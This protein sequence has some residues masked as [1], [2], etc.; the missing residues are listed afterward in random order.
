MSLKRLLGTLLVVCLITWPLLLPSLA[1][2]EPAAQGSCAGNVLLNPGFEDGFSDRG[3]GQVTVAN[4][5]N[6]WYQDGPGQ[7]EGY[8]RRPEYKP[9]DAK[10]HT[11]RRIH[12][13]NFAQKLFTTF[14]THNAGLFQQVQVSVGSQLTFSA[15]VQA[16]SSQDPNP[17]KVVAPGNYHITVGIDP[18]GGTDGTSSNVVWVE[19][20]MEYNTWLHPE[21]QATAKA[22]T[23]TVFI[24]GYN[25]FRDN[26]NDSYWD[27]AC[28]TVVKPTPRTTNT[29]K[30]TPTRTLTPTPEA[31]PTPTLTRTPMPG[32]ICISVFEDAN[33]NGRRDEGEKLVAGAVVAI[34]DS[35]RMELE[36]HTTDGLSEPTC[37]SDLAAGTYYLKRLNPV[38]YVSTV[39][40]DW[41]VAVVTGANTSVELGCKF[42]PVP[43]ATPTASPPPLPTATPTPR[44]V[45]REL[46]HSV[47]QVSGILLAAFALFILLGLRYLRKLT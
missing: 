38:G 24:R 20:R 3:A 17:D 28:L 33:E 31:S 6:P 12:S 47:Y 40:D 44:P 45:L 10:L 21:V 35:N 32:G 19:P 25:E 36:K 5:W 39:P 41:G 18:N 42:R 8:N 37:L 11:R 1:L 14:G 46:G 26:F 2:A 43:S 22:G 30:A 15:W 29:P 4:G 16:W 13:G 34:L 9:E 23:I 7:Q 27:D